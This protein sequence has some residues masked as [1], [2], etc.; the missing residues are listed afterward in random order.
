MRFSRTKLVAVPSLSATLLL[1]ACASMAPP[2]P[3]SLDLPKPPTDLR[4]V[5]K[6]DTV[7]LTWTVPDRTTDK[8]RIRLTTTQGGKAQIGTTQICRGTELP[9]TQCGTP[10]GHAV[11]LEA[12]SKFATQ[13]NQS[14]A[15][16]ANPESSE[17]RSA[18]RKPS[19]SKSGE[20]KITTSYTDSLPAAMESA[21]PFAV[22]TYAIE[23]LN[24]D[25][26]SAG[27]SN[28]V[29]VP[30]IRTFPPPSNFEAKVTKEGVVLSWRSE[31]NS[32]SSDSTSSGES[33]QHF[34]RVF[35]RQEGS[36]Q[37]SS[38]GD[39]PAGSHTLTDSAFEWEK[40][41]FYCVETVT[42]ITQPDK[43]EQQIQ[44]A[45]STEVKVFADDVFPP[46]VPAGLQA[47]YSGPGQQAFIDLVWAPVTDLDLN[48]YNVYR[49]EEGSAWVKMNQELVKTP[50][51][52]DANITAGKN[53]VYAVS[54][55]DVRG[56][57][58]ARSDE[59][60]ERAP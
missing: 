40:T 56:N 47:V 6:G 35:R 5:R 13:A 37:E 17:A 28:Q 58:S 8:Q 7:V 46:A 21:D 14:S 38:V 42:E 39:A 26:R 60:N 52:R 3:P 10:V 59:A 29:R 15:K 36:E 53:Y 19:G 1:G 31:R 4:A 18:K 23:V 24:A 50:A 25:G 57:E 44:G 54:A 16:S 2:Q 41:Y 48:G 22:A 43:T 9:L 27:L 33:V 30:T 45:D 55:V 51:Y 32:A 20:D 49:R 34:Y 11:P 12:N